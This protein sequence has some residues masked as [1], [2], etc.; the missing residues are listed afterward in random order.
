LRQSS[1]R[2]GV[3]KGS[4]HQVVINE[5]KNSICEA[6]GENLRDIDPLVFP[7][8]T[9]QGDYQT[10]IAMPLSKQLNLSPKVIAQKLLDGINNKEVFESADI[11][12]PGFVNLHLSK[13]LIS[14]RIYKKVVDMNYR[15]GIPMTE[16]RQSV[17]VDFSSP[18]IA[19]EMHVGH[20][21][22]TIIGDSLC[23]VLHFIGHNVI[24]VNHVGDWGTQFG[25]LIHYMKVLFPQLSKLN[26]NEEISSYL[27]TLDISETVKYYKEAKKLFDNSDDFKEKSRMEVVRLQ[28]QD[29]IN[30]QLW[31]WFCELSRKEYDSVYS[32]LKIQHL[33]ERGE[34]FYSNMLKDIVTELKESNIAE[35][36]DGA[37]VVFLERFKNVNGSPL[38]LII[39]KADGGYLYATTD[40]AALK[41]RIESDRAQRIIYVTDAGQ[42][43]HFEMVF[44]AAKKS[45]ILPPE[46]NVVHVPFGLVLGADGKKISSR[47]Q[48]ESVRLKDLLEEAIALAKK[49]FLTRD[50]SSHISFE[51]TEINTKAQIMGIAA[52]KY[53][54][55]SMNRES[56]YRFSF[57]K[58]LSLQ[59]NT[60]PY[61]LYAYVR[62]QGILRKLSC[63][64]DVDLNSKSLILK[65]PLEA[66]QNVSVS[67]EQNNVQHFQNM[68]RQILEEEN[69]FF[70]EPSEIQLAKHL[71]RS[72]EVLYDVAEKLSPHKM[73][74][75]LFELSQKFNTFYE[76]CSVA[77]APN[78]QLQTSRIALCILTSDVLKL[79]L[80]LLGIETLDVI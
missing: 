67:S 3:N 48:G 79:Y 49:E 38:P 40:L 70:S 54:D 55:L 69:L 74:E 78:P 15:V 29:P 46:V 21:R 19:K 28:Q 45:K 36:S 2:F 32:L 72:D 4:I 16:N 58:M 37:I 11:S 64:F 1:R 27:P 13:T 63:N 77:K 53:A 6:F 18:N 34:S 42:A 61:M 5:I 50:Q 73:C 51:N 35:E 59:G 68:I 14:E 44:A 22:S 56:N 80:D 8:K 20:L 57:E 10:N 26:S 25:M 7:S 17:V 24:R 33:V 60:A 9:N 30:R 76:H 47:K 31:L 12:G 43:Q 23:R 52:V 66:Q 62:I 41:Y 71:L 65:L 39:Q 75:Y